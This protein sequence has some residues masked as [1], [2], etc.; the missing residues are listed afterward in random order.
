MTPQG[1]CD[2]KPL[3]GARVSAPI[4][5]KCVPFRFTYQNPGRLAQR[6]STTLT[7]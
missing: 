3:R 1:P 7:S 2:G 4:Q 6:E 5:L